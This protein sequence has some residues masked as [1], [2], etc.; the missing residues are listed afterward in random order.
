MECKEL[1]QGPQVDGTSCRN[2]LS[3]P[4]GSPMSEDATESLCIR[5]FSSI[6]TST[7]PPLRVPQKA[8]HPLRNSSAVLLSYQA[9]CSRKF[10][11]LYNIKTRRPKGSQT[12]IEFRNFIERGNTIVQAAGMDCHHFWGGGS[13]LGF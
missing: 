12:K 1:L 6:P 7:L 11:T 8:P 10:E 4:P 5:H 13:Y 9:Y 2:T 3:H